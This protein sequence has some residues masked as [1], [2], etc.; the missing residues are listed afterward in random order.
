MSAMASQITS[1][2]IV[3]STVYSRSRSKKTSK[4][5]VPC[6]CEGNLPVTGEFPTQRASNAENISID[7]HEFA[8]TR[9]WYRLKNTII[10]LII[11]KR[12]RY[13]MHNGIRYGV[14][15]LKGCFSQ[16]AIQHVLYIKQ[17]KTISFSPTPC[18]FFT[19]TVR[20]TISSEY[21]ALT[22]IGKRIKSHD[23]VIKWKLFPHYWPF[24]RGIHPH[25]GQWRGALFI[26]A[27][28]NGCANHRDAGDLRRHRAHYVLFRNNFPLAVNSPNT[29]N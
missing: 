4:L 3:Y 12:P 23:A 20:D 18:L 6:L 1:L 26:C 14:Q 10:S 9:T 8:T 19:E 7:C 15:C 24:V 13:R 5:R 25:K 2:T 17:Y 16:I 27:S 29:V 28:T 11:A 22:N 21:T